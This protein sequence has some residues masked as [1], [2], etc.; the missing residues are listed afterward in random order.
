MN[1]MIAE[2]K[3]QPSREYMIR[4]FDV[5]VGRLHA[6]EGALRSC[7]CGL[8]DIDRTV[9]RYPAPAVARVLIECGLVEAF[10]LYCLRPGRGGSRFGILPN[11]V[12]SP[13]DCGL[14]TVRA[15]FDAAGKIK[16]LEGEIDQGEPFGMGL[17]GMLAG[18][19]FHEMRDPEW[20]EIQWKSISSYEAVRAA[21]DTYPW[22]DL[23]TVVRYPL[24]LAMAYRKFLEERWHDPDVP[25]S[26]RFV[27]RLDRD[28]WEAYSSR[29]AA[30]A[31]RFQ[32]VLDE[33]DRI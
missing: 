32:Q 31:E 1:A 6:A 29:R 13:A 4:E 19:H 7:A 22:K 18:F 30:V 15:D 33:I 27:C 25:Q 16:T 2:V 12:G 14:L 3:T 28:V 26:E 17:E 5:D 10:A 24:S 11:W 23:V 8:G 20:R 21:V 9:A